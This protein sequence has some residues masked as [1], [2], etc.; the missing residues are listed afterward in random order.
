MATLTPREQLD[1]F[2]DRFTPDVAKRARLALG[3]MRK[4]CPGAIELVYDNYNALAIGFA[5]SERASEA[6]VSIAVFPKH[7][8]LFF[9]Q[10]GVKL[11]D[12]TRRLRGSGTKVRHIVVDDPKI[13]DEP[14]VRKLIALALERAKVPLDPKKRRSIVIKSI[15]AK[16]RPRA[17]SGR[18][19]RHH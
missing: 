19:T 11:P 14:D 17:P 16:Q 4:L 10:D 8:S 3:K 18:V 5:P 2:L 12:P 1:L 15:A 6:V 9:L 13:L 7:P